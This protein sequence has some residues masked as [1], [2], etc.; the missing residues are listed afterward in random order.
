KSKSAKHSSSSKAHKAKKSK[1]ITTVESDTSHSSGIEYN[2]HHGGL[3]TA[4]I[5][6]IIIIGGY[7][8]WRKKHPRTATAPSE[9]RG[10]RRFRPNLNFFV[11]PVGRHGKRRR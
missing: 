4:L 1:I 2:E 9:H 6:L 3:W 7:L 11:K 8:F 10:K 5:L